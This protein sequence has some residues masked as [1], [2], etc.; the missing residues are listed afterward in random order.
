MKKRTLSCLLAVS[1]ILGLVGCGQKEPEAT[2]K[3]ETYT[4]TAQGFGGEVTATITVVDGKVTACKLTG[5]KETPDVGGK[6][7]AD[8]ENQVVAAG[9]AEIDGVSGATMTSDAVRAAVQDCIDQ[10]NGVEKK[11]EISYKAG[12]YEG[13]APGMM[14]EIKVSVTVD[15]TSIKSVDVISCN[16]TQMIGQGLDTA[17]VEL[18]PR[19]IVEYQTL[20]VDAVTGAT[21]TSNGLKTAVANALE[22]S[23]VE[24]SL[25]QNG[26]KPAQTTTDEALTCDVVVA[27]AGGAG[28]L[29]AI[30]AAYN[31]A[32]VIVVEKAGSLTGSS[33]RNGGLLMAAGTKYIDLPTETLIDFIYDEI[34]EKKVDET[35]IRGF[36]EGSNDMLEFVM[37]LGTVIEN[38]Q[39]IWDGAVELPAVYMAAAENPDG[40]IDLKGYTTNV[41]SH[42]IA[43]LY[44]KA[45]ELGVE[46]KF[47]T[48]MTSLTTDDTGKVTGIVCQRLDGTTVTV[49]ANATII[50]TGGFG[51]DPAKIAANKTMQ[52]GQYYYCGANTNTGEGML[53]AQA[54]GADIRYEDD[55]PFLATLSSNYTGNWFLSLLVTPEG[56]RFTKEYDYHNAV[57]ADLNRAGFCYAYEII[58]E[59]FAGE[60][61][62]AAIA[63]CKDGSAG[64]S[65]VEA[66]SVQELAEKLDMDTAVLEATLTRYNE[67]CAKGV[68]EDYSKDANYMIPITT[69]GS[70][71]LY[72]LKSTV[73]VTD[74]FG[75][76][77]TDPTTHVL[78]KEGKAISGLYAA[79]AVAF[80]DWIDVEYPGCGYGFGIALYTGRVAGTTA[81]ADMGMDVK[82]IVIER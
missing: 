18:L 17:P 12:T 72:A 48:P 58:D 69:D 64:A 20:N 16:D 50:A 75:G 82:D 71:K 31:G 67:L 26:P 49:Q 46:F 4:A 1:M 52:E 65:V 59:D 40:E 61:Y 57:S 76:I 73:A 19:Q 27:G 66:G 5:D 77:K 74:S 29:A 28:L 24:L 55:M 81:V 32:K 22:G 56:K 23:G 39:N 51:G 35:R 33:T 14:G 3:E 45:V 6:A 10:A 44:K 38:V 79:G 42:Y 30:E 21:V 80:T 25:L 78:D 43:P 2:P 9:G 41:G 54:I 36:V 70:K 11:A 15:G 34:G 68:D 7:L 63:A 37:S 60:S 47:N 53:A 8:L 62:A 13:T